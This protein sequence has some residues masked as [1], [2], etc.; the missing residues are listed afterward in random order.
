MT[1]MLSLRRA[2]R[3][4]KSITCVIFIS[5]PFFVFERGAPVVIGYGEHAVNDSMP[6]RKNPKSRSANSA[7]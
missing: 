2:E 4:V 1:L 7:L 3:R 6:Q 5:V